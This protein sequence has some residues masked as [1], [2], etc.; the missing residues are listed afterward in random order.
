M[1]YRTA[2]I[3]LSWTAFCGVLLL[4]TVL[5]IAY[6]TPRRWTSHDCRDKPYRIYAVGETMHVDLIV[7]IRNPVYD[8]HN[9][10]K[11]ELIYTPD[12]YLRMGWGD[13]RWYTETPSWDQMNLWDI[14]RV[15]FKPGNAS[16]MYVQSYRQLPA[17]PGVE[18]RCI[19]VDRAEYL[20]LVQFLQSSFQRDAQGA[21][22]RIKDGRAEHSGFYAATGNYSVLRTC[23]TWTAEGLDAAN[24][25]T[26]LWSALAPAV[27]RQVRQSCKCDTGR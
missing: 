3:R 9:F 26:P 6:F 17:D 14:P 15:L 20:N 5:T 19:A 10:L 22:I 2:V 24:V 1:K 7:P 25:P 18:L 21:L 11:T 13:R 27:M 8:W 4:T 16:V 23:N 12:G